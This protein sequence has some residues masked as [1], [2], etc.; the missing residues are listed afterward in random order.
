MILKVIG[1]ETGSLDEDTW[2]TL[3]AATAASGNGKLVVVEM[4]LLYKT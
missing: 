4:V 3:T 2:E 1:A